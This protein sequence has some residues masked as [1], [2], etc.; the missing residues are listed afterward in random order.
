MSHP[1]YPF[2]ATGSKRTATARL[3]T[4]VAFA[5][6]FALLASP[7]IAQNGSTLAKIKSTGS[8]ACGVNTEL[9][10]Y[11]I[12]DAHGDLSAFATDFCKAVA[13]A[14]LGSD[15]KFT[16]VPFR[17]EADALKALKSGQIALLSTASLNYLNTANS[18]LGFSRP[19][20]YDDQALL[21]NKTMGVNSVK[22]L[23][24]KK[25][26]YISGTE[27]EI[28]LQAY[29]AR[30][31]IKWLPYTFSEE[32]EMEMALVTGNCAATTADISQ[33]AG[34]RNTFRGYARNFVIL[35]DVIAKDPV[36]MA[37]RLGDPQWAAIV[38]WTAEV[39]IQ[40][41]EYGV[42]QSNVEA[43]KRSDDP[44]IRRLLGAQAGYWPMIGVDDS[45]AAHVIES[46]G[47]YGEIFERNLGSGSPLKIPRGANN[48]STHGG[49]M[50]SLP[51]R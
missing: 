3:H 21:V 41:E 4:F 37:Y 5:T 29:M 11:T 2:L 20:L 17:D 19:V 31:N 36:A 45:F 18:G 14:V 23:A 48:L 24:G 7:A 26:C 32:G 35:P 8:L 30:E 51:I 50:E 13:V 9:P 43:M 27:L 33:L 16:V 28:Q 6:F 12:D 1:F 39:L 10:E 47:N 44:V 49:L 46:V 25:I 42:T 15:A 22:D 34:E 38:N 40:A